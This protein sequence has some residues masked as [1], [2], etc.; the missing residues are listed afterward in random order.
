MHRDGDSVVLAVDSTNDFGQVRLASARDNVSL[1]VI[2]MTMSLA[3]FRVRGEY[4]GQP[5]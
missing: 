1:M 5:T 2:S 4:L 3:L